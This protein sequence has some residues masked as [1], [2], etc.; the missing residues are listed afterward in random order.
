MR[1]ERRLTH[2][3]FLRVV[4][5]HAVL[6]VLVSL[7]LLACEPPVGSI[8]PPAAARHAEPPPAPARVLR[9][10]VLDHAGRPLP[11]AHARLLLDTRTLE[12]MP[13]EEVQAGADGS[14]ALSLVKA[15]SS[16]ARIEFSGV[17]HAATTI[18]VATEQP[19]LDVTVRL[20]THDDRPSEVSV[21]LST[22]RA[23][24]KRHPTSKLPDGPYAVEL[25]LPDGKYA[26]QLGGLGGHK[27]NGTAPALDRR[28]LHA[29][30]GHV[31]ASVPRQHGR[32][33]FLHGL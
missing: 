15:K 13:D 20:G 26:Y 9:G 3:H 19:S 6:T 29:R 31:R 18:L 7:T 24:P 16:S 27:V 17:D 32:R 14:F 28:P 4:R 11:I 1:Y 23:L 21:V 30:F 22:E 5:A 25:A 10:H 2:P 12:Q 33:L 8:A